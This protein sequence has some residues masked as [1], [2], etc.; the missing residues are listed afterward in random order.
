MTPWTI[1]DSIDRPY[2]QMHDMYLLLMFTS[3]Y[4]SHY[5]RVC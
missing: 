2:K 3:L 4:M 1:C 5:C